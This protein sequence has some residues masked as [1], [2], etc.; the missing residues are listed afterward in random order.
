M[1][2]EEIKSGNAQR[3][4]MQSKKDLWNK[5]VMKIPT[6]EI[7]YRNVELFKDYSSKKVLCP[8]HE[9]APGKY[10]WLPVGI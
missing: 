2:I 6:R 8:R 4:R 5:T 3:R 9:L 10:F 7:N 1:W